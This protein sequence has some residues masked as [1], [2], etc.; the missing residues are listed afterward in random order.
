MLEF[1]NDWFPA[2]Q[3]TAR[4]CE[5]YRCEQLYKSNHREV[6][7][8]LEDH[9][10]VLSKKYLINDYPSLISDI[11]ADIIYGQPPVFTLPGAQDRL[12]RLVR[13]NRFAV[14]LHEAE[15]NCSYRG[16]MVHKVSLAEVDGE[17]RV[18]IEEYP[19]HC[20][21]VELDPSNCRRVLSQ[22]LAWVVEIGEQR[23]LRV[24]HHFPGL[25]RN[26][27]FQ[28]SGKRDKVKPC[29]IPL[30]TLYPDLPEEQETRVRMPLLFH[31]PN[32]RFGNQYWGK[33]DYSIGLQSLFAEVNERLT[34]LANVLRKHQEPMLVTPEGT[35]DRRGNVRSRSLKHITVSPDEAA[36]NVPRYVTWDAQLTA[37][38]QKL[39]VL[40]QKI[41]DRAG[42]SPALLGRD[43]AGSIESSLA[44]K[45]RFARLLSTSA[46]KQ[47]YREDHLKRVLRAALALQTAWLGF[48]DV[49]A[50]E[51]E[52]VWRNGLPKDDK[53]LTEVAA[54][55]VTAGIMSRHTAIRY[56]M[57]VGDQEAAS[58]AARIDA[59]KVNQPVTSVAVLSNPA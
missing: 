52:I 27:L 29:A 17:D 41:L 54:A 59:E 12:D 42:I 35:G 44:M 13:D 21:F 9:D 10:E 11:F 56:S 45:L 19:A 22:A 39:E 6:F 18:L 31:C 26:Q 8:E 33:S 23:Y 43:K 24:E 37:A 36:L 34:G 4:L 14:E 28:F 3:D 15:I 38:F 47:M 20:Y 53:E 1:A 32:L 25:V 7:E 49:S 51:P 30:A 5:Y 55:R 2:H 48:E 57:Q 58:E 40:D 50:I 16:D 46:R